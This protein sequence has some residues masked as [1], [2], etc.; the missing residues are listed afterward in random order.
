[1]DKPLSLTLRYSAKIAGDLAL[2][3]RLHNVLAAL[4]GGRWLASLAT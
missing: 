1:M 2:L 4:A 3:P